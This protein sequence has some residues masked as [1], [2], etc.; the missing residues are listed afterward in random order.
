MQITVAQNDSRRRQTGGAPLSRVRWSPVRQ[1][2]H[3]VSLDHTAGISRQGWPS[4]SWAPFVAGL[5]SSRILHVGGV[6]CVDAMLPVS[7]VEQMERVWHRF[8]FYDA[9]KQRPQRGLGLGRA[10]PGRGTGVL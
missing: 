3:L 9:I 7:E 4:R 1:E 6:Q 8:P 2:L 5:G 10:V